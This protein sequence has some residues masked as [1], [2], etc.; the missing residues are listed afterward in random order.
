MENRCI[1]CEYFD[2]DDETD[3]EGCVRG[4]DEDDMLKFITGN[5]AQCPY[6][7]YYH[8]YKT[9]RKQN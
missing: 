1:S 7:K 2:Y 5:M 3:T 6:Y 9:V 4:L 8:E